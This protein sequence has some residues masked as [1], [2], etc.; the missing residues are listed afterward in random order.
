MSDQVQDIKSRL[1]IV[2][3]IRGY[4]KIE[5]AG[6]NFK[7]VCP[8][9]HEKTP[10]FFVSPTKQ[11]WYCFGCSRGG[12]VFAFVQAI[13]NLDFPDALKLL[14]DRAGV[15]L[16]RENPQLRSQRMRLYDLVESATAFF[17]SQLKQSQ[18]AMDY[19][20]S[21]GLAK[22]TIL[23]FRLGFAPEGWRNLSDHLRK[24]G[25]KES[26]ILLSGL[27]IQNMQAGSGQS[28]I[29]DRF[30]SRIMFPVFD[31]SGRP[32]GFSGRILNSQIA[33][34]GREEPK[35]V[36]TPNTPVYDKSKII[37][38]FHE[39]KNAIRESDSAVLVEGNMDFLMSWQSG[40]K[41]TVAS[42]GT[43]LTGDHLRVLRRLASK[44]LTA[45]DMDEAGQNATKRGIDMALSMDFQIKVI[46][47]AEGAKD[48]ADLALASPEKWLKAV[49][50]AKPIMEY[51]FEKA[52]A[53]FKPDAPEGKKSIAYIL[54]PEIKR[55]S[56]KIEQ[57]H[58]ISA[59]SQKIQIKEQALEEE[60]KSMA[61]SGAGE[62]T[63][64][65]SG[66]LD[67]AVS[68]TS[69]LESLLERLIFLLDE[70]NST[71]QAV[72]ALNS[73]DLPKSKS[74]VIIKK[75][76]ASQNIGNWADFK[77]VLSPE[78]A[79]FIDFIKFKNEVFG[80]VSDP[81]KELAFCLSS[82]AKI[83]LKDQLAELSW[84]IKKAEQ[85]KNY[86]ELKKA[87][88]K[89]SEVSKKLAQIGN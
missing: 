16:H 66:G 42:S 55:I 63:K 69:K 71:A 19:L 53:K 77:A 14:A 44:L 83:F 46:K 70:T 73:F 85:E 4:V 72:E 76:V 35:Y 60:M 45:F 64:I 51:Y 49:E 75:L 5:K 38:G 58:W 21:R 37:F 23:K 28:R 20:L 57:A 89:F 41:N 1:D 7:G 43:A 9:H 33:V 10:S 82:L 50:E 36:N 80:Q 62:E 25:F 24:L 67:S 74:G 2:E 52:L 8:F 86:D 65:T 6:I 32:V 78:E 61:V 56:S 17:E 48:P 81:G 59:L 29:Y 18:S 39:A 34:S 84:S 79:Q 47:M 54:L 11:M 22:E 3:V 68:K 40:I 13:D 15:K 88:D 27:A 26:E 12:D 31:H 30:R 87:T